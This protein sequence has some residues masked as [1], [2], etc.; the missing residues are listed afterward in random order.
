MGV[1]GV[2]NLVFDYLLIFG[3][4]GF[5]ELGIKGAAYATVLSWMFL[6][7]GMLFLLVQDRLLSFSLKAK[8]STKLIIAEIFKLGAPTILTQVIIPLT[9]IFLTFLLAKQSFTAVAAFGVAG[10]IEVLLMIGI[11][12]VSSSITPFIAQNSGAEKPERIDEAIVFGGRASTFLG[13]FVALLLFCFI[14]PIATIFSD[15]E[16]VIG[17]TVTYFHLVGLSYIF[18]GLFLVTTSIFSGLQLPINSLKISAVKLLLFTMPL[19]L[20]GSIW[21]VGGI[22][23]GFALS[24]VLAGIYA[25]NQIQKELKRT[26]SAL[27]DVTLLQA[28]KNDIMLL[29]GKR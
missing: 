9:L 4:W 28:Y 13:L 23:T 10:R 14:K 3:K 22:F 15:H 27:A 11:F 1:A 18:Y 24:N 20:I 17:Y 2:L 8:T 26:N 16:E 12:G 19:T 6:I 25:A 29:F 5:P 7:V 21:G